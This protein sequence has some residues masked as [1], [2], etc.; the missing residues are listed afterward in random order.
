MRRFLWQILLSLGFGFA[1][2]NA[3]AGQL[4]L[5]TLAGGGLRL[6]WTN[7]PT[8][9]VL[10]SSLGI[11]PDNWQPVAGP[12]TALGDLRSIELTQSSE[13]RYFRLREL[14][15]ARIASHSP[16]SGET[17]V[18]VNREVVVSFTTPLE[19]AATLNIEQFFATAA[20]RKLLSRVELGADRR[21][22][23]LFPLEP[24]PA[25]T[26]VTVTFAPTSA[27]DTNGM[28]LDADGDGQP[29]GSLVFGYTTPS[30]KTVAKTAVV[31][32]VFAAEPVK[33]PDGSTTNLPLAGV[34]ITVDGAEETLRTVTGADGKFRLDPS[35]AGR[36]FVHVDGRTSPASQWP[37]G[38]YYPFVGKAWEITAGSVNNLVNGNGKLYLPLVPAAALQAV[39]PN[40]E[41]A[42]HLAAAQTN[43]NALLAGVEIT[44]PPNALFDD[45]GTRGGRIGLAAVPPDRLPEPLP[46]GLNLPLVIT[47]QTSGPM[48]FAEPVRAKFPNLPDP[49]TGQKLAP[50]AK[51]TLWSFNHDTGRWQ[52]A[53]PATVTEDGDYVVSDPGYGIRQP[54]W[55]GVSGNGLVPGPAAPAPAPNCFI[56][57]GDTL[58]AVIGDMGPCIASLLGIGELG[59]A[60]IDFGT[61]LYDYAQALKDANAAAQAGDVIGVFAGI[62]NTAKAGIQIFKGALDAANVANPIKE[63]ADA[64]GCLT[65][66]LSL[67]MDIGCSDG[68]KAC[69]ASQGFDIETSCSQFE[70]TMLALSTLQ[71][72]AESV[73]SGEI[74]VDLLSAGMDVV[75]NLIESA[76]ANGGPQRA[77]IAR[78]LT[79]E[80]KAEFGTAVTNALAEIEE[81]QAEL[82]A[83]TTMIEG[84]NNSLPAFDAFRS[85][86]FTTMGGFGGGWA[87]VVGGGTT[88]LLSLGASGVFS[89]PPLQPDTIYGSSG[90]L[91]AEGHET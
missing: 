38:A 71:T 4:N 27:R 31:G 59:S 1:Q 11:V 77:G 61:G 21:T 17:G 33:L 69:A 54:G 34:T 8:A 66:A 50:G 28:V 10:E 25:G 81:V 68:A 70:N 58:T 18:S 82:A 44:I 57:E 65:G 13:R 78:A 63:G 46:P 89:L 79:P 86:L 26:N 42:I 20:G 51:T 64:F 9:K 88:N 48:N 7:E 75:C 60:A 3:A 39:S 72:V 36:I 73:S 55:H 62:C 32:Q 6:R 47:I 30:V 45:T 74:G 56:T 24:I 76:G 67:A 49:V 16:A 14:Q 40:S 29:G 22:A 5:E 15:P 41:T 84:I 53:G 85:R 19:A 52:A 87:A 43:G 2:F 37:D 23:T 35:P 80:F 12:V 91:G 83:L 90:K